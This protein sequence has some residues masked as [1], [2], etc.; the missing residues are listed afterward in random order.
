MR[1]PNEHSK[2]NEN[3]FQKISTNSGEVKRLTWS[4]VASSRAGEVE[5]SPSGGTQPLAVAPASVPMDHANAPSPL[6]P[7]QA[8]PAA[9]EV[10]A[11]ED[12]GPAPLPEMLWRRRRDSRPLLLLLLLPRWWWTVRLLL[13]SAWWRRRT[14]AAL[15]QRLRRPLALRSRLPDGRTIS[16]VQLPGPVPLAAG[17]AT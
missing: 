9:V 14:G 15:S 3:F 10:P 12:H 7:L 6:V 8:V 2:G 17:T 5:K 1:S 4:S 13:L 16:A 11:A